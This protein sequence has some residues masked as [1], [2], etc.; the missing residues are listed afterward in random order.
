MD[1]RESRQ[2]A[3]HERRRLALDAEVAEETLRRYLRG[4]PIRGLSR[5][6]IER[7]LRAKGLDVAP[8]EARR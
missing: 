3:A 6:R 4:D 5:A 8:P 7:A 1:A 2:L